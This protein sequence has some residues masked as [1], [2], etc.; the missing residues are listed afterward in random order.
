MAGT[1]KTPDKGL[2]LLQR[3]LNELC[4]VNPTCEDRGRRGEGNLVV[5]TGKGA[6]RWRIL[7]CSTCRTE[8]SE[9]KGT[10]LFGTKVPPEKIGAVAEHLKE[11]CGIR[12]TS[13][14]TG[15]SK[16]G[17]TSL[18]LR[19]GL[20]A[21]ALHDGRVRGLHVGEAQ[22]DEK[23]A[24]VEKKQKNCD[25]SDPED[26]DKGDQWDHTALDVDSRMVVSLVVG[27]RDGETLK[28]VV[29]DFADRTGG[30]PPP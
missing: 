19:L 29:R 16:S 30:A 23:W 9:R 11:G 22:F 5:R 8:F 10:A 14:L 18:A 27:K 13:R 26:D 7:R 3:P 15:V 1:R 17:V 6:G 20:H 4:C 28:E 21:R 25:P 2:G 24:F 12:K